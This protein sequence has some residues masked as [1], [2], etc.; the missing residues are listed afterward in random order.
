M[1]VFVIKFHSFLVLNRKTKNFNKRL[2]TWWCGGFLQWRITISHNKTHLQ[3]LEVE[4]TSNNNYLTFPV[5][6]VRKDQT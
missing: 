3:R 5:N 4:K 6:Y 2:Q 1:I